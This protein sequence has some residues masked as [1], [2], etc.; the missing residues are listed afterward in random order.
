MFYRKFHPCPALQPFVECYYIW[1]QG[2]QL[3][4]PMQVESPPNGFTAMVFIYGDRYKAE[5]HKQEM[6]QVPWC[7]LT[8]QLTSTYHL[9]LHGRIGMAGVV[10]KPTA[11]SGI[12]GIPMTELTNQRVAL[13]AVFGPEVMLLTERI[14]ES[15]THLGK[16]SVIENYLLKKILTQ[17]FSLDA[18][19]HAVDI[20]LDRQG[21][22]SVK[23]LTVLVNINR[24]QFER[25]F[26]TKV[27]LSPKY[28]CRLKRLGHICSLLVSRKNPDWQDV[29]FEG[30]FYDQSHFIKDFV[31]FIQQNPSLYYKQHKE[32]VNF[33]Q[34]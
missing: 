33:L 15:Q 9:Q 23:E 6:E 17:S 29:V 7:F 24:R 10:F 20:I 32:L 28:Y 11:I 31:E 21:I 19:D 34:K 22:I 27:G 18:V 16:I 3:V 1:E 26:I 5:N 12:F 13:D 4:T 25:K 2:Q 14:A 8:G 30:G